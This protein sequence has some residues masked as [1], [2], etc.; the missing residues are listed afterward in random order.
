MTF[1]INDNDKT[2]VK[3]LMNKLH[4]NGI[5]IW[6]Q[7]TMSDMSLCQ[8]RFIDSPSP[9]VFGTMAY[10]LH[11]GGIG[12]MINDMKQACFNHGIMKRPAHISNRNH[13]RLAINGRPV[14]TTSNGG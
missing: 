5:D 10:P 8:W 9:H 14:W 2:T 4:D 6:I 11:K 12:A 7:M 13:V 3:N 1:K